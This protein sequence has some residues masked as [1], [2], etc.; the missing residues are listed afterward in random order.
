MNLILISI[1]SIRNMRAV[2]CDASRQWLAAGLA[3]LIF[4]VDL[5]RISESFILDFTLMSF[6]VLKV[7]F[8]LFIIHQIS[9]NL[10]F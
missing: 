4:S 2:F 9:W 1:A 8:L 6:I 5:P 3:V 7:F 10:S